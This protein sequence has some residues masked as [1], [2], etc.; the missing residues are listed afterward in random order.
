MSTQDDVI[1]AAIRD[2]LRLKI[3]TKSLDGI[4]VYVYWDNDLLSVS[5]T[6]HGQQSL[7]VDEQD[8]VRTLGN[9][10]NGNKLSQEL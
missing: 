7:T 1:K 9:V 4:Q 2:H 3:S 8:L 6:P 5:V 10:L